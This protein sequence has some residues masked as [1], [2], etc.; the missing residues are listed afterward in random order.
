MNPGPV[1]EKRKRCHLCDGNS[2][3]DS[4]AIILP[5][6]ASAQSE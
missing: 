5:P 3:V 2:S 4:I 1:G 6:K